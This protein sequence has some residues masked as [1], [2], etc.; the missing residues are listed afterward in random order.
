M[1]SRDRQIQIAVFL[2]RVVAAGLFIQVGGLKL[3]GWFG[4]MP[5]GALP[6]LMLVAGVLEF[7]GGIAILFGLFTRPVAFILSGEM[8]VAYFM[9]H[10]AQ[11]NLFVPLLNQGQPAV[12]LCFIFLFLAAY[13]A[14][15]WSLDAY[16]KT[17]KGTATA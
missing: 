1:M 16:W 10:A 15:A 5:G 2:L 13:G 14:G 12:L 17:R 9:G 3:W 7:F 4:G 6:P 8:A 11:G